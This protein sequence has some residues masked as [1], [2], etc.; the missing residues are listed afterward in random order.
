MFKIAK[1]KKY[2]KNILIFLPIFILLYNNGSNLYGYSE[3]LYLD[4]LGD[5]SG[6]EWIKESPLQF[7][8]GY[9][10][11][12]FI[13]NT[14]VTHWIIVVFGFVYLYFSMYL[15]DIK[16][17]H[18]KEISKILYFTPFFL[19]LF[20]W[21][22][23]PDTFTVGSLFYLVVFNNNLALHFIFVLVLIFSHPQVGLIYFLLIKYLKIF[24]LKIYHFLT[25]SIG[26]VFYFIYYIQLNSFQ[27]RFDVITSELDRMFKTIFTNTLGGFIS[28]FMWLWIVI[29]LSEMIKDKKFLYSF[30]FIF[31]ISFHTIDHTRIFTLLA[32]PIIL[33]LVTNKN[34]LDAFEN[35]FDK[36]I[37]YFLGIFQI[38][39]RADG[40]IVD[41][42][43]FYNLEFFNNLIDLYLQSVNNFLERF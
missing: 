25:I 27:S 28:L 31:L 32:V 5:I 3:T 36:K 2:T 26:Y 39:K 13:N 29:F 18:G 24:E 11:N 33:Y 22:G 43:N 4:P 35:I 41:G 1:F 15:F 14:F 6:E 20:T 17:F 21:M 38:Q 37:M 42:V 30:L 9:A 23:K 34:F 10:I 40:R 16:K 7:F 19:I 12:P 8:I